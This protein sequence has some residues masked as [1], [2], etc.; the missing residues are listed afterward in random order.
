MPP[1][2]WTTFSDI[3]QL[4]GY[5]LLISVSPEPIPPENYPVGEE[6]AYLYRSG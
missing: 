5:L 4:A 3:K 2:P 1:S 6:L